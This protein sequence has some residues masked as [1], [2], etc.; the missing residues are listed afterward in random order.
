MNKNQ[1]IENTIQFVKEKLES[2]GGSHD[3]LHIYRVWKNAINIAKAEE[4]DIFIVELAALLHDITDWKYFKGSQKEGDKLIYDWLLKCNVR[5][6]DIE[7]ILLIINNMGFSKDGK[8][9]S[10][11]QA[12]VQDADRLDAIGAIGIARCF[13]YTGEVGNQMYVPGL[14]EEFNSLEKYREKGGNKNAISHFYDK[15][16]LIKDKMITNTGKEIAEKRHQYMLNYL[17]QFYDECE[18]KL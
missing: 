12:V 15:L 8:M 11:E 18:G 13:V 2:Y 3:W 6:K 17:E 9:T 10:L 7:K 4:V 1:I 16:L 5:D 14:K